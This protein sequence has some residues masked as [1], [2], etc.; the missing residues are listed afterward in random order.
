INHSDEYQ[1][2]FERFLL[3]EDFTPLEDWINFRYVLIPNFNMLE[4]ISSANNFDPLLPSRYVE[5]MNHIEL[6]NENQKEP[7]LQLMDVGV[8]ESENIRI[9]SGIEFTSTSKPSRLWWSKCAIMTQNEDQS[10]EQVS[11]MIEKMDSGFDPS[12]VILED[13]NFEFKEKELICNED[14]SPEIKLS[15]DMPTKVVVVVSS[16]SSG[17]L[18]L[19]DVWYPGWAVRIDGEKQPLLKANYLFKAVEV[20]EGE[21]EVEFVYKPLSFTLGLIISSVSWLLM[22]TWVILGKRKVN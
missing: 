12:V 3:F 15:I 10:F 20:S 1:L 22:L 5:W 9:P 13:K 19:A 17:Y 21:H 8:V 18:V 7:W 14:G 16:T 4:G 2:K 6:L 11:G